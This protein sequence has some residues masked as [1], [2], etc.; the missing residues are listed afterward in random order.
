MKLCSTDCMYIATTLDFCPSKCVNDML[1]SRIPPPP[2]PPQVHVALW[3][4]SGDTSI[5]M[6]K[7]PLLG[8]CF[9][10]FAACEKMRMVPLLVFVLDGLSRCLN[11]SLTLQ[12]LAGFRHLCWDKPISNSQPMPYAYTCSTTYCKSWWYVGPISVVIG[13]TNV[14]LIG[15]RSSSVHIDHSS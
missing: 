4:L 12:A 5:F 13:N 1:W 3:R 15:P 14:D 7:C 10:G 8:R 2:P 9:R 11:P 6:R